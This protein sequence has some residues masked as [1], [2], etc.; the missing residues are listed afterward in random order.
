MTRTPIDW[1]FSLTTIMSAIIDK[2]LNDQQVNYLADLFLARYDIKPAKRYRY[3]KNAVILLSHGLGSL[4]E[5]I[6]LLA[7]SSG[8]EYEKMY[9]ELIVAVTGLPEPI[10]KTF[11]EHYCYPRFP[12]ETRPDNIEMRPSSDPDYILSF[13][14]GVFL[15]IIVTNYPLYDYVAEAET[16]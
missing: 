2:L 9:C 15:Y 10:Y 5:V 8:I 12:G 1:G 16:E 6:R 14:S 7:D 3:V 11:N 13:L 4:E